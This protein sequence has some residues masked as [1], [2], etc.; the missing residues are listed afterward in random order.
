MCRSYITSK[1]QKDGILPACERK[2]RIKDDL[3]YFEIWKGSLLNG[4]CWEG[5]GEN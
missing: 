4:L 5:G 3:K 1:S 2:E